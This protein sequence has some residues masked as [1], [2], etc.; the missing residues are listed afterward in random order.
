MTLEGGGYI[1]HLS[2]FE[3]KKK[4]YFISE[5]LKIV[6]VEFHSCELKVVFDC[7]IKNT[8]KKKKT[9]MSGYG[10]GTITVEFQGN[11]GSW[12]VI[13]RFQ[14]FEEAINFIRNIDPELNPNPTHPQV[15][16]PVPELAIPSRTFLTNNIVYCD[17]CSRFHL[18]NFCPLMQ[19][20]AVPPAV[21][22]VCRYCLKTNHKSEDC[23]YYKFHIYRTE[24]PTYNN[25]CRAR[26]SNFHMNNPRDDQ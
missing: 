19:P 4:I 17:Y 2:V 22:H 5:I 9:V 23:T 14:R 24:Q 1:L 16:R 12:R 8:K 10:S 15:V 18:H 25:W 20:P 3:Q 11:Q 13:Q 21:E 26:F 6:S 7:L